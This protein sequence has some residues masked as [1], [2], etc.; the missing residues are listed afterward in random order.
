MGN[1][2]FRWSGRNQHSLHSFMPFAKLQLLYK[3]ESTRKSDFP[4]AKWKLKVNLSKRCSSAPDLPILSISTGGKT[5][6]MALCAPFPTL[7]GSHTHCQ[8]LSLPNSSVSCNCMLLANGRPHKHGSTFANTV[9]Q[10]IA[11]GLFP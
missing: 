11:S 2:S 8:P 5:D 9:S 3:D 1:R 7:L 10:S 6:A 4:Q